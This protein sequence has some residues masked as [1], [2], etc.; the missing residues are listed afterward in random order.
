MATKNIE[1]NIKNS[2][3]TYDKLYPQT[4]SSNLNMPGGESFT[5]Y[6]EYDRQYKVGDTLTTARPASDF[7]SEWMVCDGSEVPGGYSINEL[8]DVGNSFNY[9]IINSGTQEANIQYYPF[10]ASNNMGEMM[11]MENAR[12]IWYIPNPESSDWK[13]IDKNNLGILETPLAIFYIE[14]TGFVLV[15]QENNILNFY[16]IEYNN[17][18]VSELYK[19]TTLTPFSGRRITSVYYC[20][21]VWFAWDG[22]DRQGYIYSSSDLNVWESHLATT[23]RSG[24]NLLSV[25]FDNINN[26]YVGV[27]GSFSSEGR[28]LLIFSDE[29]EI[30]LGKYSF[31]VSD[32]FYGT[33]YLSVIN[34]K[35]Y[36][37]SQRSI[38]SVSNENH[39]A[40]MVSGGEVSP[41][42]SSGVFITLNNKIFFYSTTKILMIK[43]VDN[44]NDVTTLK[45]YWGYV[46]EDFGPHVI[47]TIYNGY[48]YMGLL[49]PSGVTSTSGLATTYVFKITGYLPVADAPSGLTTMIKVN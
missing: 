44:L 16:K 35:I 10:V 45:A 8:L 14:G 2:S 17:N 43:S 46:R 36:L 37:S 5:E 15:G 23:D 38:W 7:N 40:T 26:K 42:S 30:N 34:E 3:N 47:N 13:Q 24:Y 20:N 4:S 41:Y 6:L 49:C 19:T 22:T 31:R 25:V 48:S 33:G 1:M 21:G 11:Y 12:Y 28:P 29:G 9:P 39:N 27:L 18:F 32:A